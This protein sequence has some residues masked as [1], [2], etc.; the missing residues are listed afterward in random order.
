M[1]EAFPKANSYWSKRQEQG[2]AVHRGAVG[3]RVSR[4]RWYGELVYDGADRGALSYRRNQTVYEQTHNPVD[5]LAPPS[6]T[7][8][9]SYRQSGPD[10]DESGPISVAHLGGDT[11][12]RRHTRIHPRQTDVQL[13]EAE[14]FGGARVEHGDR[15][16]DQ[17]DDLGPGQRD[18]Q[19]AGSTVPIGAPIVASANRKSGQVTVKQTPINPYTYRLRLTIG[20]V[21]PDDYGDYVC[22]SSNSMGN[23]ETHVTVTSKVSLDVLALRRRPHV[24]RRIM[25]CRPANLRAKCIVSLFHHKQHRTD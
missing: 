6:A 13:I 7:T 8:I 12:E 5:D 10:D 11:T 14:Q 25:M 21:Q 4:A 24:C 15:N 18:R 3:R 23:A 1:I 17:D 16:M 19:L 9:A 20:R 22:V 2:G